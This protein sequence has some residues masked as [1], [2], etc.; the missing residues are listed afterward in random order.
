VRGGVD[1][2]D[3]KFHFHLVFQ[4]IHAREKWKISWYLEMILRVISHPTSVYLY[5]VCKLWCWKFFAWYFHSIYT[6]FSVFHFHL[7]EEFVCCKRTA[8]WEINS[9]FKL[10]G[11]LFRSFLIVREWCQTEAVSFR[12][13]N[14]HEVMYFINNTD[15]CVNSK[16]RN[17]S[18]RGFSFQ[19]LNSQS[20]KRL[21]FTD[22][23]I[24]HQ[25]SFTHT[26]PA[27]SSSPIDLKIK[28][29]NESSFKESKFHAHMILLSCTAA[30][31]RQEVFKW[32][33]K[34]LF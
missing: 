3:S 14:F 11:M 18:T 21:K 31:K 32:A 13:I 22:K 5:S 10:H 33:K 25:F 2:I 8:L 1:K 20:K 34:P 6:E 29:W 30:R 4:F 24:F 26:L 27:L 12:A 16:L 17:G 9:S 23:R 7:S 19:T 15:C 28:Y